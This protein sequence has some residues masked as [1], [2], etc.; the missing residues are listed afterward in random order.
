MGSVVTHII[1]VVKVF[2]VIHTLLDR[3]PQLRHR[4]PQ[5]TAQTD[6]GSCGGCDTHARWLPFNR[7]DR[8][9]GQPTRG[10]QALQIN[11]EGCPLRRRDRHRS[12]TRKPSPEDSDSS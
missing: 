2:Q 3:M 6:E 8:A 12:R 7:V 5:P 9:F 4:L 10:A 11:S 1:L